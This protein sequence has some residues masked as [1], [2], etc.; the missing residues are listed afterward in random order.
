MTGPA[1]ASLSDQAHLDE[2]DVAAV[3]LRAPAHLV[4]P[5]AKRVWLLS[6]AL[7][8]LIPFLA[9]L[10][11][12]FIDPGHRT[13]QG[14]T[15]AVMLVLAAG[16]LIVMPLWRYRVHRWEVTDLAVYTQTGWFSQ[17]RQLAPISR[18]QTVD[19]E[20]GP[21]ERMFGLGSVKV[22]TA[23]AAG[24]QQVSGLDRATVERLVAELTVITARTGHDAT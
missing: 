23:S 1:G 20:F 7:G 9:L 15:A 14:V 22:T 10:I 4:D 2:P 6:A 19:S 16:H 11:W 13:W 12:G 18:I 21:I 5:R 24:S 3:Q 17:Q 8:W